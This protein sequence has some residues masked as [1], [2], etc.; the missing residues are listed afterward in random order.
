MRTLTLIGALSSAVIF[1]GNKSPLP[2]SCP[3]GFKLSFPREFQNVPVA[4]S[5]APFVV[6]RYNMVTRYDFL[7]THSFTSFQAAQDFIGA[8]AAMI[9]SGEL[10]ILTR[11]GQGSFTRYFKGATLEIVEVDQDLGTTVVMKYGLVMTGLYS[12]TM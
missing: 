11:T 5:A 7:V 3:D 4:R 6:D 1:D 12:L 8:R 9:R 10:M 2:D